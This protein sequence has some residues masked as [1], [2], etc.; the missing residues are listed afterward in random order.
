MTLSH[1]KKL[2]LEKGVCESKWNF[3]RR[4]EDKFTALA[5]NRDGS[6]IGM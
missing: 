2:S 4:K 5:R 6:K 1:I 3:V